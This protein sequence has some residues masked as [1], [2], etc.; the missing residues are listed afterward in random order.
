M[1]LVR[2]L[3]LVSVWAVLG[4]DSVFGRWDRVHVE[5][6]DPEAAE[7]QPADGGTATGDG[8]TEGEGGQ[9]A[10]GTTTD[11][12]TTG[13]TTGPVDTT[14][15]TVDAGAD[16]LTNSLFSRTGAATDDAAMTFLWEKAS[17]PGTVSF[18]APTSLTTN[19]SA[20]ASGVY[21]IRL[22]AT[23]ASGNAASDTFS[24]NWD[25]TPP[26]APATGTLKLA[27]DS[28]G[29]GAATV[30]DDANVFLVWGAA[31]DGVGSGVRDYTLEIF[32][33]AACAGASTSVPSVAGLDYM[34]SGSDGDT[35]S[36]MVKAFDVLGQEGPQSTCKS[37]I[38]ID[39]TDPV[40]LAGFIVDSGESLATATVATNRV[41]IDF[42]DTPADIAD[43]AQVQVRR[44]KSVA[45]VPDIACNDGQV[46]KTYTAPYTDP[47]T[48]L[49]FTNDAGASFGY[50]VCITDLAGRLKATDTQPSKVSKSQILFATAQGYTGDLTGTPA[51]GPASGLGRADFICDETARLAAAP[52]V[53]N[54]PNWKAVMSDPTSSAKNR[55]SIVGIVKNPSLL[56]VMADDYA[57]FWSNPLQNFVDAEDGGIPQVS[58]LTGTR[59]NGQHGNAS[60]TCAAWTSGAGTAWIGDTN[61]GAVW[62]NLNEGA[63]VPCSDA[64]NHYS[65]YCISQPD[66]APLIPTMTLAP[67]TGTGIRVTIRQPADLSR[68]ASIDLYRQGGGT[69]PSAECDSGF[70]DTIALTT[71]GTDLVYDDASATSGNPFSY[72]ACVFDAVGNIVTTKTALNVV[73]H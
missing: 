52:E 64:P 4:C 10:G 44:L 25:G 36:F 51:G 13:G 68:Y 27:A 14:A 31:D 65:L 7:A 12:T 50:R 63:T 37:G 30:D 59:T 32:T 26:A 66:D 8:G 23:D 56:F 28:A 19:V 9:T 15:P 6:S 46:A 21:S 67:A 62:L 18:S 47:V 61:G 53:A 33:Q 42:P 48:F 43:Y 16:D 45:G 57:G 3:S 41:T 58:A 2:L 29:G 39:L 5:V 40:A 17:G 1:R 60:Q 71:A 11:G 49:D 54:E 38:K 69:A 34:A 24:L 20:S 70:V 72:R 73:A 22:T 35:I 55:L